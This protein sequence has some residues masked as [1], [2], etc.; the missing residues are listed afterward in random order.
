MQRTFNSFSEFYPYYLLQHANPICRWLHVTGLLSAVTLAS[1]SLISGRFFWLLAVPVVGYMFSWV[2]HFIF[3]KNKPAT[4]GYPLYSLM[5]DFVMVAQT[6][7][8]RLQTAKS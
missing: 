7:T 1:T 8:G 6:F 3:E 5:G 2:G 4:F